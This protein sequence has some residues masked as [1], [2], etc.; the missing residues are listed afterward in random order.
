MS[1]EEF[2]PWA[3]T[4]GLVDKYKGKIEDAV[5]GFKADYN[6]G[7]TLLLMFDV[8]TDDSEVG[9]G[10]RDS[11]QFSCGA[12]WEAKEKGNLAVRE[13]SKKKGF[14]QNSGLG[15]LLAAALES[16][17]GEE[18]KK[19]AGE[20]GPMEAG[21]WN[22]LEFEFERKNFEGTFNGEDRKW[23]R[24]LPI[25]FLGG[26]KNGT[27]KG[28]VK[29]SEKDDEASASE[30]S[31]GKTGDYGLDAGLL[32][33]IKARAKKAESHDQFIELCFG[34]IEGLTSEAE[35]VIMDADGLY[36]EVNG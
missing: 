35:E 26:S 8:M 7:Q 11:L 5:F 36:A 14:N 16:G 12:G 3:L 18:L 24:M 27:G 6:D 22:G 33:K 17:A 30:K 29:V 31:A 2:D 28:S 23:Q 9:E 4:S 1:N 34:E 21:I 32:A 13:D 20:H 25:K 19:R 15:Q 10:G